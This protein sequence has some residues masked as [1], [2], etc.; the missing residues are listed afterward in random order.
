VWLDLIIESFGPMLPGNFFPQSLDFSELKDRFGQDHAVNILRTL[1][2]FEGIPEPR[3]TN[4]SFEQ[5]LENVFLMMKE[6]M[7]FQTRH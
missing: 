4:L 7:R 3:V 2:Q 1:E 5:R 6:N